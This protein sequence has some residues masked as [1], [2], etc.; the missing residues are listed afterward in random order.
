MYNSENEV[1]QDLFF[2]SIEKMLP[3]GDKL[4]DHVAQI[5]NITTSGAYKKISNQSKLKFDEIRDLCTAFN[6]SFQINIE[7][8]FRKVPAYPFYSDALKFKPIS[9]HEYWE[10][11]W[12][13]LIKIKDLPGLDAVYLT[14][15]LPFFYY[16][17]FP[18]LLYFKMYVWNRTSW[19]IPRTNHFYDKSLFTKDA[20]LNDIRKKLVSFYNS[21]ASTE[22]WNPDMLRVTMMQLSYYVRAGI[23]N[24]AKDIEDIIIDLEKLVIHMQECA[25]L[26]KKL[27]FGESNIDA[28]DLHIY[29]NELAIGSEIIFVKSDV[30][31][32]VYKKYDSPNYIRSDDK[33]VC[34][35]MDTLLDEIISTTS[36]ISKRGQRERELFFRNTFMSL[37]RFQTTIKAMMNIDYI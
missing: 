32:L 16:L 37:D 24:N 13:H 22:I 3:E 20:E 10:N 15:E 8:Q 29:L 1:T 30:Y 35:H 36:L 28:K 25:T 26:G 23:F 21:Y 19:H 18:N 6:I 2:K 33:R 34:D 5:L 31:S 11:I 17:Q 7:E 14:N 4:V 27:N 9:Y 12:N